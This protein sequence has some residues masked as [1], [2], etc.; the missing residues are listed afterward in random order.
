MHKYDRDKVVFHSKEDMAGGYELSKGEKILKSE[1]T[2]SPADI[3]DLLEL[4]N[5]KLYIENEVYLKNWSQNDIKTF[6]RKV[7]QYGKFIGTFMSRIDDDNILK[8]HNDLI[9]DFV[10]SFWRLINDQ[11]VYKRISSQKISNILAQEPYQIRT[12]LKYKGLVDMYNEVLREF[13]LAYEESAEIIL[14]IYEVKKDF[15][16]VNWYLPKSLTVPDKEKIISAYIDSENCNINYLPIIQNSKKTNEFVI[17]DKIRLKAKRKQQEENAK[18]FDEKSNASMFKYGVSISYPEKASKIKESKVENLVSH[19]SYSID[20]IKDN[21]HPYLLYLNFKLLFEYLDYQNRINLIS[22]TSQLSVLERVMGVR[23][24]NEYF[25]GILFQLSQITSQ[26][27]IFTYSNV[28]RTL[29]ISI[30]EILQYVYTTLFFE[31]YGFANNA[32]LTIPTLSATP[33]EKVRT[34]APELESILKRYKLFVEDQ[35]IDFELLQMSSSPSSMRDIPS[36]NDSKYIYFNKDS[37][38]A[39]VCSN[40]FFSDQTLLAYVDPFKDKHY[41]SFFDLLSNESNI[42]YMNYE[43]YQIP[44]LKYL[45]DKRYITLDDENRIQLTNPNRVFIFMDLYENEV[46]SFY[47]YPKEIQE[48]A[49]KM[50]DERLIFFDSSLFAKPEQ[51]YFNF[52]LNRSEF[53]NGLDLRNS[54]LHGTQANPS[55]TSLHENSYL[56]YLKLL[57]LVIFKIED[58]LYVNLERN[59][60]NNS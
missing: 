36:L 54:Y 22:K 4:Y 45:I 42:Y 32:S 49:M 10:E 39:N 3:N 18:F 48:E 12:I 1:L 55:E 13:L 37:E 59:E 28:L 38:E 58:D 19:Y 43:E 47:H 24:K 11:K 33:L 14:S 30:E 5:I 2:E 56:I 26:A 21:A 34:I 29:N 9:F 52:Y 60:A 17:S 46:G 31:K 44:R 23:S 8:F 25:G 35:K 57:V 27:Q 20:F 51:D 50:S 6:K 40:L 41:N 7:L 15:T 16:Q 53:T